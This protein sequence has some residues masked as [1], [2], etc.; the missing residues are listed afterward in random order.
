MLTAAEHLSHSSFGKRLVL[1]YY[2]NYF[3]SGFA[4]SASQL[5]HF[6]GYYGEAATMFTSAGSLN[7]PVRSN[8]SGSRWSCNSGQ[9]C[10]S[11]LG[12]F[13]VLTRR[14]NL[15]AASVKLHPIHVA[16]LLLQQPLQIGMPPLE[17]ICLFF[18][19]GV[20]VIDRIH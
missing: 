1:L 14:N 17:S 11:G 2:I 16:K 7:S 13:F 18:K 8:A 6:I 9:L 15:H 12:L 10:H 20:T 19:V 5:A 3:F 4:G